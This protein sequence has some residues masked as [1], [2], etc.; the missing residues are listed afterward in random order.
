MQPGDC[1]TIEVGVTSIFQD[2]MLS[3]T[4]QPAIVQG[5]EPMGWTFP[6][7]WTVSTEASCFGFLFFGV[8]LNVDFAELCPRS[9]SGTHGPDH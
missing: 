7:G 2:A 4:L 8:A 1:F 3:T 6:D 9:A 5:T